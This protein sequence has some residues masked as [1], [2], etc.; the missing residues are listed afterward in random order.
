MTLFCASPLFA[1]S[2]GTLPNGSD[3]YLSKDS[4]RRGYADFLLVQKSF[5]D[6]RAVGASLS[7]LENF[8]DD[9][10]YLFLSGNGIR[11]DRNGY[12]SVRDGST[13][14]AFRNV[15]TFSEE[16]AD[17][18]L[19]LIFDIMREC[20]AQQ[21]VI[22]CG[23]IN[24]D[25]LS[26][27]IRTMALTIPVKQP[28]AGLPPYSWKPDKSLKFSS[29]VNITGNVAEICVTYVSPRMGAEQFKTPL[30]V[31][32]ERLSNNL[33]TIL[34]NRL[35]RELS[36]KGIPVAGIESG[37]ESSY[38]CASDE[39][40]TLRFAT[41]SG[42]IDDAVAAVSSVLGN[43]DVLGVDQQEMLDLGM[44]VKPA[45]R[46]S[47]ENLFLSSFIY[48]TPVSAP[49]SGG[50]KSRILPPE[51]RKALFDRYASALLDPSV[52]VS[53]EIT[54][55]KGVSVSESSVRREFSEKW[56]SAPASEYVSHY[57]DTAFLS[58]PR[59]RLKIRSVR[60]DQIVGG[61]MWTLSNGVR[62]IF[63]KT[64]GE[65]DC[66]WSV[67]LRG[68]YSCA[69]DLAEGESAFIGDM[70]RLR[71]VCG[72]PSDSF[73]DM[74]RAHG[75]RMTARTDNS[76]ME[77]SCGCPSAKLPLS[78]SAL[79]SAVTCGTVDSAA[80][81]GYVE[82]ERLAG[83]MR[84]FT[85]SG[86]TDRIHLA[87]RPELKYRSEKNVDALTP[88]FPEKA[89]K[90]FEG[91]FSAFDEAVVTIVGNFDELNL[92][93][94]VCKYFGDY[95]SSSRSR[96]SREKIRE[97]IPFVWSS[98]SFRA[99]SAGFGGG[100]T[101]LAVSALAPLE[102]GM[103]THLTVMLAEKVL[104]AALG[105]A[106]A[107]LG[108]YADVNLKVDLY[109]VEMVTM[110]V[111]C[112]QCSTYGLPDCVEPAGTID[113]NAAIR[114]LLCNPERMIPS[115][116]VLNGIKNCLE[117]CLGDYYSSP[118]G[119]LEIAG[120]RYLYGK[121]IVSGYREELKSITGRDVLRIF[122]LLGKGSRVEYS[123]Y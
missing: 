37:Y 20:P 19:L 27:R 104:E 15:P 84:N 82:S 99:A 42:R 73:N 51:R 46:F 98:S 50:L 94:I 79:F 121:D 85:A 16:V 45:A 5:E 74:L 116:S 77:I 52:G 109:P 107:P 43:L 110:D 87:I 68:G 89:E 122:E 11:Y 21:A 1:R 12:A 75:I 64:D 103:R 67:L 26:E 36:A 78:L 119:C 101:C 120:M 24:E 113:I 44:Q 18:T 56:A 95:S 123:L 106:L 88:A 83:E 62:V 114:K 115:A 17:S 105:K 81:A 40:H 22:I 28:S 14:Y 30:P 93:K 108:C 33:A 47:D 4:S 97:N 31:V 69:G 2:N 61:Q 91:R 57:A 102:Y 71:K 8:H 34:E 58:V 65:G 9:A 60:Q 7:K 90:Y 70:F 59:G 92:Q 80:Y 29:S 32:T 41:S 111:L 86:I 53:L 112:R 66:R 118:D 35:R 117:G 25:K 55:P 6:A 100:E 10:P 38:E 39:R 72:L 49:V 48:G 3:W 23:D 96:T 13:V 76:G 54:A 63:R